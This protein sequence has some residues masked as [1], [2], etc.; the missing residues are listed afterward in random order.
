MRVERAPLTTLFFRYA[1]IKAVGSKAHN[2]IANGK[3]NDHPVSQPPYSVSMISK[4][5]SRDRVDN[6]GDDTYW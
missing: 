6:A 2:R 1:T 4:T 5:N 3:T